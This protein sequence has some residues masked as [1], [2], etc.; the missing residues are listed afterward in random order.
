[1][2]VVM[3]SESG[4][5]AFFERI[6][7]A[8]R[9]AGVTP[10]HI[11]HSVGETIPD[12]ALVD[13]EVLLAYGHFRCTEAVMRAAPRLR[14]VVSPWVGTDGFDIEAATR[15]G[16]A[17]VNGQPDEHIQGMAEATVMMILASSYGLP[18]ARQTMDANAIRPALPVAELLAGK[19]LGIIGLGQIGRRVAG[20]LANWQL[21]LKA[22]DPFA[23][24][25]PDG[26]EMLP[27][28]DLLR[29]SDIVTLHTTLTAESRH[30]ID[31]RRLRQMKPDA[32]LVNTARGGL[33]DEAALFEVMSSGHLRGAALDVFE[34]EPLPLDS[35]LRKLSNLLLTPHMIGQTKQSRAALVDLAVSNIVTLLSGNLPR[36]LRNP[37]IATNWPTRRT[38]G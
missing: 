13:A 11:R 2:G 7:T 22:H 18:Q 23:R 5:L 1:M 4:T 21:S 19:T 3:L 14:A 36:G 16:I 33:V 9:R 29:T 31:A 12:A 38:G 6:E 17:I 10:T 35:P 34:T 20:L 25:I 32:I 30:L 26:I 27:L 24:D 28:D 37:A 8:L 15:L